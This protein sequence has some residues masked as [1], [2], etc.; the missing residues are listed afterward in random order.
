MVVVK[1]DYCF[2]FQ[3]EIDVQKLIHN[4]DNPNKLI[5]KKTNIIP[6]PWIW[7]V[8]LLTKELIR[9]WYFLS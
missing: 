8:D 3:Q 7:G 4:S 1:I 5:K 6:E 2:V 9:Q